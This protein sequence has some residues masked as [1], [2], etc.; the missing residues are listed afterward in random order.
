MSHHDGYCC[1]CILGGSDGTRSASDD[2]I[3]FR[4]DKLLREFGIQSRFATRGPK[5][6]DNVLP[7]DVAEIPQPLHKCFIGSGANISQITDAGHFLRLLRR[8][9]MDN[10]QNNDEYVEGDFCLHTTPAT[11]NGTPRI[12]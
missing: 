11:S 9:E 3:N 1:A 7:L 4:L 6:K 12:C 2:N 5:L 10:S 8:S